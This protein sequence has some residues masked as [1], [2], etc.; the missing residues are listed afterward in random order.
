MAKHRFTSQTY[1]KQ[2]IDQL[3][4]S[5]GINNHYLFSENTYVEPRK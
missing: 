5:V 4:V 3:L 1:V 2:V